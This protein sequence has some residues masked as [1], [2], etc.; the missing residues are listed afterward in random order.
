MSDIYNQ[1]RKK[2]VGAIRSKKNIAAA[3]SA[4]NFL[5]E[6]VTCHVCHGTKRVPKGLSSLI[7][8]DTIECYNCGGTGHVLVTKRWVA[9]TIATIVGAILFGLLLWGMAQGYVQGFGG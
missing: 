9:Y 3:R 2:I 1:R 5:T 4:Q 8:G 7:H 6:F